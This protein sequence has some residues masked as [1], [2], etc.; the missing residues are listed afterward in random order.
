MSTDGTEIFTFG[1]PDAPFMLRS[2]ESLATVDVA[3]ET[4]GELNAAKDNVVVVF[5]ALTGSQHAAG[6][7]NVVPQAGDLWTDEMHNGW[8]DGFI[9]PGR[10]IDTD[11]LFVVSANYLGGCYGTTGPSSINPDTGRPYGSAFP[12]VGICDIVD[13]QIRLLHHLGITRVRAAIGGSLGG[14]LAM[15]LATR[16]PDMVEIVIPIAAGRS[17]TELQTFHNFEQ[18]TAIMSD[19]NFKGGDYYGG[20]APLDGLRLARMIGH[21]TF[22]SLSA[23]AERAQAEVR[24]G[25]GPSGYEL[26]SNLESYMWHQGTKFTSRFDANTYLRIMEVWQTFDLRA[27][28]H[29]DTFDELFARSV[30]QRYMVFSIDSDVCFY[31]DQQRTLAAALKRAGVSYR[32][33]TVHSE[34][35]HDSFLLEPRLFAPHLRDTL[36]NPWH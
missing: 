21:K 12:S 31:P 34:K 23:L 16:Y 25:Q 30:Y 28:A 18:I 13:S 27:E 19:P 1:S 32:H 15:S 4:Y 26:T 36:L 22:V 35:G 17:V 3:Y 5:H 33:I 14:V 9:G 10:A 29:V 7:T 11:E 24:E 20:P 2:G 8:W 6:I